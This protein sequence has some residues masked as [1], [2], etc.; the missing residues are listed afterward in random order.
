MR[1]YFISMITL[2][3]CFYHILMVVVNA[4]PNSLIK[5][6]LGKEAQN[7]TGKL[8]AQKGELF[9]PHPA[10]FSLIFK[11]RCVEPKGTSPWFSPLKKIQKD[12][13]SNRLAGKEKILF[14]YQN[15]IRQIVGL[16]EEKREN[17]KNI[18]KEQCKEYV[19]KEV[20]REPSFRFLS[21]YASKKCSDWEMV[22]GKKYPH[23]YSKEKK[24][25]RWDLIEKYSF[26]KEGLK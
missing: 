10:F 6:Y 13:Y 26:N 19:S 1:R 15:P 12:H 7:Y 20:I 2:T 4:S 23:F 24:S 22:L 5:A 21:K 11:I 14:L 8:F 3:I 9:A 17:C 16:I 25:T 18:T